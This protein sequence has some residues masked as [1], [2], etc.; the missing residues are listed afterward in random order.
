MTGADQSALALDRVGPGGG[1]ASDSAFAVALV[2]LWKAVADAGG[3]VGFAPPVAR[4]D[5]AASAAGLVEELRTGRLLG[6]VINRS[7]R[8]VG[9]ALL[10]PGRHVRQHS[11]RIELVLVDPAQVRAGLGTALMDGLLALARE[12]RLDRL[13]VDIP[14]GAGLTEFFSRFGFEEWG[15]RPGWVRSA[16][17]EHDEVLLGVEL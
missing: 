13:E 6:V 3:P 17:T 14:G 11:G 7:R 16:D 2:S 15:R 10:R 8:L 1:V 4:A 5:V 12:R 9:V